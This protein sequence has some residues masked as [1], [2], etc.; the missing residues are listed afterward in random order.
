MRKKINIF[1]ARPF[2]LEFTHFLSTEVRRT[3]ENKG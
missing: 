2:M 1:Y 3:A